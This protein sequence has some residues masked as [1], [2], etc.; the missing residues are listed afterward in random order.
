MDVI[1]GV[2]IS[3][4]EINPIQVFC[5][6]EQLDQHCRREPKSLFF[7]SLKKVENECEKGKKCV[8]MNEQDISFW[9]N[10][11]ILRKEPLKQSTT[12]D[13]INEIRGL[14]VEDL[15]NLESQWNWQSLLATILM[16]VAGTPFLTRIGNQTA[17]NLEA[18]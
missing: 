3:L 8:M 18:N 1:C 11:W 16:H 9:M 12:N 2:R 10:D 17:H 7:C 6:G 5:E 13:L 15:V 4:G 14:R